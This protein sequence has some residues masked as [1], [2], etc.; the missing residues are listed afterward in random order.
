[1][2][3]TE[4]QIKGLTLFIVQLIANALWSW[5]FFAWRMGSAAIL[6]VLLLWILIAATL[7]AFWRVRPLAGSLLVPYLLWVTYASALTL[8]IVQHNP[9][10][11]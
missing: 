10:V 2:K 7:V 6:D 3:P 11:L 9:N 8:W 1:M 5:F 4:L